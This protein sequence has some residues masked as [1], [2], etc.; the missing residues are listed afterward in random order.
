MIVKILSAFVCAILLIGVSACD[1]SS[2]SGDSGASGESSGASSSGGK[3][4]SGAESEASDTAMSE[5]AKHWAKGPNGWTTAKAM[6]SP[7][8]PDHVLQQFREIAVERVDA[9]DL[10]DSDK[11][12][13]FE[14][15]G[16]V[17]F[18]KAPAREAGDSGIAFDG[19]A[20]AQ[21]MRQPGQWTQWI[22]YTPEMMRVQKVKG[23]WQVQPDTFLLHGQL[24]TPQD[25][26]AA[27]VSP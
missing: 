24:P 7:F 8:A 16:D 20:G 25:F 11:L 21:I 19:M 6:G 15:A 22:D 26:A 18:K 23:K 14:W 27:G 9:Y 1:S 12:N 13:G 3:Q 10:S 4:F 5:V 17:W 2:D